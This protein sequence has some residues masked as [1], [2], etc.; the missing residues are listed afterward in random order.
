MRVFR[1]TDAA[2]PPL[3]VFLTNPPRKNIV[4]AACKLVITIVIEK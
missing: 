4:V 2:E 3:K 1:E